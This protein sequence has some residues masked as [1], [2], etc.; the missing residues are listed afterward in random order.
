MY[1]EG[2]TTVP[3]TLENADNP[4]DIADAI[5]P[6]F[7]GYNDKKREYM[8]HRLCGFGRQESC[9]YAKIHVRT[10]NNW[11]QSDE[12]FRLIEQTN[13]L[14]L[15]KQFSKMITLFEFTRNFHLTLSND[16][17]ILDKVKRNGIAKLSK[18]EKEY[19]IK[20]RGMYTPQQFSVLEELFEGKTKV[21]DF[22][23]EILVRGKNNAL[24]PATSASYQDG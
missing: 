22:D 7:D 5:L 9:R 2:M 21:Q 12:Q 23:W 8:S 4:L 19:F 10:V 6:S 16:A 13:L 14:T 15:R 17:H 20:M 18:D 24:N 3:M 1:P 11:M